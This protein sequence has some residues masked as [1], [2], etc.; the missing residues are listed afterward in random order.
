M[1]NHH[2]EKYREDTRNKIQPSQKTINEAF[3]ISLP[4][5]SER[6]HKIG[7]YTAK[8]LQP[9][10]VEDSEGFRRLVNTLKPKY[11]KLI[12]AMF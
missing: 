5:D 1:L 4:H 7:E 3:T 6:N 2:H 12:T 9:F 10:S 8:D 11:K